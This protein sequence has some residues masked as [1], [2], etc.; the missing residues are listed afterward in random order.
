MGIAVN[1]EHWKANAWWHRI[2]QAVQDLAALIPPREAF[3]LVD[4][5]EWGTGDEI[6]GRRCIPFLEREKHIF[7]EIRDR[8]NREVITV[9]ELLS[10]T[11]KRVGSRREQ[12]LGK[13][14]EILD[15]KAHFIEIDAR[16]Q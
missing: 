5:D 12:Y 4:G 11:N 6:T 3:I 7:L 13:R 15:S 9:V 16:Q 1:R 8:K 14:E 2:A 10:P